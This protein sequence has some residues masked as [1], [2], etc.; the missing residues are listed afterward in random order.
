MGV[1]VL[2]VCTLGVFSTI[3]L[4]WLGFSFGMDVFTIARSWPRVLGLFL[5]YAPIEISAFCLAASASQFFSISAAR[6]LFLQEPLRVR[7]AVLTLAVAIAILL[8]AAFV[9]AHA[10]Q[11]IRQVARITDPRLS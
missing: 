7:E 5:S 9:E 8:G 4:L 2:G 10:A 11:T 6:C 1:I 3:E